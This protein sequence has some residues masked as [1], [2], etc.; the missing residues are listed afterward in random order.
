MTATHRKLPPFGREHLERGRQDCAFVAMGPG[1]WALARRRLQF[2]PVMVLPDDADPFDYRWPV[3]GR[4]VL[5][6]EFGS[7]D[8]DRLE[9]VALALLRAGAP[10]V[11]TIRDALLP[12]HSAPPY[13]V[14]PIFVKD[15]VYE[16]VA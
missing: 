7:F 14:A 8:T 10:I 12:N 5:L 6:L 13:A 1:A 3:T 11:T 15:E 2:Y 9:R 4:P 16:R